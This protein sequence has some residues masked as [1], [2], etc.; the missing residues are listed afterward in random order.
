[1]QLDHDLLAEF[2][3]AAKQYPGCRRAQGGADCGHLVWFRLAGLQGKGE[4]YNDRHL[5]CQFGCRVTEG[6]G[7]KEQP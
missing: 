4:A 1:L 7:G 5:Y 6:N 2:A 3:A